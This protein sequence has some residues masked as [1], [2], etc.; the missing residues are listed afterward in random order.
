MLAM[1]YMLTRPQGVRS[2]ILAGPAISIPRY[3]QDVKKLRAALPKDVQDVLARHEAAGT[4]DSKEYQDAT[5][6]FYRRH[7]SRVDPWPQEMSSEGFGTEVYNFMWGPSEFYATGPL[8]DYDRTS[9]LGELRLPVL[10]TA[11]RYD[12]TTPEQAEWYRSL[13][14]GARLVIME[15]SAHMTMLDEPDR[16]AQVVRDFLRDVERGK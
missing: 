4:T 1:D 8:K 11:G 13:V 5:M 7:L 15:N 3:L 9:R 10:F 16:Y 12:E 2:L 14:P 6:V